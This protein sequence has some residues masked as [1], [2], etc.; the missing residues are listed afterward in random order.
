MI[1][2]C[3]IDAS[4]WKTRAFTVSDEGEF[5][6]IQRIWKLRPA[7]RNDRFRIFSGTLRRHSVAVPMRADI[8]DRTPEERFRLCCRH[9]QFHFQGCVRAKRWTCLD[10]GSVAVDGPRS[11][12][13]GGEC[14]S[15]PFDL[16]STDRSAGYCAPIVACSSNQVTRRAKILDAPS[17]S[18]RPTERKLFT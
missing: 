12:C 15:A 2:V 5:Q 4:V 8:A 11:G 17:R 9:R 1:G 14:N 7:V 6:D 13:A 3:R 16:S 18:K 10:G